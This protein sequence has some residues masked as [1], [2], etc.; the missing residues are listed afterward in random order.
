MEN[1]EIAEDVGEEI[2]ASEEGE[3]LY[4]KA[5]V[6]L[7]DKNFD[8]LKAM[9]K[10]ITPD[11]IPNNLSAAINGVLDRM[12]SDRPDITIEVVAEVGFRLLEALVVDLSDL[13]L[14][15]GM[16]R[17][18]FLGAISDVINDYALNHK[19]K[20]SPEQVQQFLQQLGNSEQQQPQQ[21]S[22]LLRG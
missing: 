5:I 18:H 14:L 11:Q 8:N 2:P 17:Q 16:T 20:I 15:E 22:G 4:Q 6:L 9:F 3:K 13:G 19:D 7:Y 21:Q 10:D 1:E 12:E